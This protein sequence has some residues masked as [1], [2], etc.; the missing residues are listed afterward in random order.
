MRQ[1]WGR[2]KR[3]HLGVNISWRELFFT[4]FF[5]K[6]YRTTTDLPGATSHRRSLS[7]CI[8]FK[9][10][11]NKKHVSQNSH[12]FCIRKLQVMPFQLHAEVS[13]STIL[14]PTLL[15]MSSWRLTHQCVTVKGFEWSV[16]CVMCASVITSLSLRYVKCETCRGASEQWEAGWDEIVVREKESEQIVWSVLFFVVLIIVGFFVVVSTL[17][18]WRHSNK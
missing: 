16:D 6:L 14:D 1:S 11:E 12:S 13:L 10:I 7:K 4:T 17:S 9:S 5:D 2:A 3:F 18:I 15:L 8:P